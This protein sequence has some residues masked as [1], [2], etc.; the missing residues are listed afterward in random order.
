M[1]HL[2]GLPREQQLLFP[3]ALDDYVGADN[4]VRFLDAFVASLDLRALG[5]QK[6]VAADTGRPPYHP[7]DLLRLYL[8]GYLHRLRSSRLLERECQRNV[9]LIWL[10]RALRPDFKT[11][12]DFRRDNADALKKVCRQFTLLCRKLNLFGGELIAIDGSKFKAVNARDRN[13]NETK[14]RELIANL[15]AK[16]E[17]Y[18]RELDQGD[19][20]DPAEGPKLSRAELERKIAALRERQDDYEELAG[21]LDEDQK[22]VSATD[23]DARLMRTR[24]G[25]DVCYNVQSAVDSRHKLIVAHDVVNEVT[26]VNELAPLAVEAQEAIGVKT[27]AA[28]AD[29][30][31]YN[32]SQVAR[33]LAHGITPYIEK[34]DTSANTKRGLFGKS[35]FTYDAGRDVYVC[36]ARQELTYR[37]STTEKDRELRYYRAKNCR[38]CALKSRCTRNQANRTIT[39]EAQEHLMEAMAAR[40]KQKPWLMKLRKALVEHPFGTMKRAMN[41]GYFLCRGLTAVRAEFSLTVLA[42]NL[43]RVLNLLGVAALMNMMKAPPVA[44]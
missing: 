43:K 14:L 22:Q 6:A 26:D 42:Y 44:G 15:D 11:I 20:D 12:A 3:A 23:A 18:L 24:Q 2:T 32:Q 29:K 1:N 33:C 28:V 8:Y 17:K 38:H 21:Q 39:R 40:V 10:L 16:I 19:D 25:A 41:A 34:T 27:L 37:F 35:K 9:E 4:P 7:G 36:P 13:Y 31:Y 5:F 30:G